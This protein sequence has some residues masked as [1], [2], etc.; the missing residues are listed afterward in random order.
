V[1]APFLRLPYAEAMARY[2][3]DKPD[4]RFG[5]EITEVTDFFADTPFRVSRRRT[6]AP[7]SWPAA[8]TA[9]PYVRRVAGVGQAARREGLAYVTV[10]ENGE[11]GGPVA[12]NISDFR[13]GGA[14]RQG[15]R[16]A[17][18]LRLL[19]AGPKTSSQAL[20][21]LRGWRSA[22]GWDFSTRTPTRSS[23]SSTRRCS[24]R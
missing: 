12:K 15:R 6:W 14:R 11:L 5:L 3:S 1:A 4:L 21:V 18:R 2:G 7:S 13:T 16:E 22:V 17:G 9:A 20:L 10:D 8:V 23:G 24:S 19:G